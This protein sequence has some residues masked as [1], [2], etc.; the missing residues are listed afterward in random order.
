MTPREHTP[1]I[2]DQNARTNRWVRRLATVVACLFLLLNGVTAAGVAIVVIEGRN[3]TARSAELASAGVRQAL[4]NNRDVLRYRR[5]FAETRD[6]PIT[7]F[8]ELVA[9]SRVQG[10]ILAVQPPC[11]AE[12]IGAIDAQLAAV[13]R[14]LAAL[15][16][17]G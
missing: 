4:E 13:E 14:R 3:E 2:L 17:P 5:D 1:A 16:P 11:D 6:C 10:D 12:D 8:R 15:A 9:V 7:Y